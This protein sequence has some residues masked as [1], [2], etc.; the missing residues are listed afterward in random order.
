LKQ[1][2][3]DPVSEELRSLICRRDELDRAI[4]ALERIRVPGLHLER[5]MRMGAGGRGADGDLGSDLDLAG[6]NLTAA[7]IAV[8]EASGRSLGNAEIVDALIRGG[9]RFRGTN[10]PLAVAQGLSRMIQ[11]PGRLRKLNRGRWALA[12][13][14]P[15]VAE[16]AEICDWPPVVAVALA[17]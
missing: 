12:E 11:K 1:S 5:R 15:E 16:R 9:L 2:V 14:E 3:L 7:I 17:G 6:M 10:P 8:L 4:A 13:F